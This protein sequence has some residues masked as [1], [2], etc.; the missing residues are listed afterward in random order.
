MNYF[1]LSNHELDQLLT[2][3]FV[4]SRRDK[5]NFSDIDLFHQFITSKI[6][7]NKLQTE[8]AETILFFLEKINKCPYK[9][10]NNQTNLNLVFDIFLID[11]E[12]Y[13]RVALKV[14]HD[15]KEMIVL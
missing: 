11:I 12:L 10:I 14:Y 6:K 5:I 1:K 8:F 3:A 13:K 7:S 4:P 9:I 15:N 2:M